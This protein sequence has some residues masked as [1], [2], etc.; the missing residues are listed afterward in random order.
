MLLECCHQFH[1]CRVSRLSGTH[2]ISENKECL[3]G[4]MTARKHSSS[5]PLKNLNR[6]KRAIPLSLC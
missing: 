3:V 5:I 6:G 4:P 1:K 2:Q